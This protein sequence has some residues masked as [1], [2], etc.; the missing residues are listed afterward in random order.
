VPGGI[1]TIT[2]AIAGSFLMMGSALLL[3]L[4]RSNDIP[5]LHVLL[6]AWLSL[7][8]GFWFAYGRGKARSVPA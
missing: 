6:V 8:I 7:G 2:V 1:V 5:L 3:P 4:F